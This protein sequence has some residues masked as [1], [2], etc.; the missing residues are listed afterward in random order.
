MV[1]KKMRFSPRW[2]TFRRLAFPQIILTGL[3]FLLALK[4]AEKNFKGQLITQYRGP[5]LES[6]YLSKNIL[7]TQNI[8]PHKWCTFL[9]RI[10]KNHYTVVD[11]QGKVL[12]D[13]HSRPKFLENH[14]QYAEV[15]QAFQG[16]S[17][18]PV[19]RK[20]GDGEVFIY[21]ADLF[22]WKQKDSPLLQKL[23]LRKGIPGKKF[24][25]AI[26]NFEKTAFPSLF[27]FNFCP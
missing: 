8:P 4:M 1:K 26:E 20:R 17:G 12:C 16:N 9:G 11:S 19:R 27:S 15:A 18:P 21:S 23:I 7:K 10:E 13:N 22:S 24:D 6:L 2:R 25:Q 14:H 3:L 5:L